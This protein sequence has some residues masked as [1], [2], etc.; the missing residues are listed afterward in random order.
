[1]DRIVV[2][3]ASEEARR[4][5]LRL[6]ESDGWTPALACAS[7]AEAIRTALR[8]QERGPGAVERRLLR[9]FPNLHSRRHAEA[10]EELK[11]H[12]HKL[13]GGQRAG[14]GDETDDGAPRGASAGLRPERPAE[15]KEN[16]PWN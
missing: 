14:E 5:I 6:L 12:L 1:M 3:F 4:R 15:G 10:L 16:V 8:Q 9:A 11:R 2:A 13:R 7:G